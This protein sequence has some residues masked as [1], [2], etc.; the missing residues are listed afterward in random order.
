M[1]QHPPVPA[2]QNLHISFDEMDLQSVIA[3]F[4]GPGFSGKAPVVE[5]YEEVIA[6]YF[7]VTHALAACNGTV[8]IE[9]ALRGLGLG[10]G[11][12]IGLP[13][14]APIMSILP[15]LAVGAIPVFYDVEVDSFAPKL[16]DLR[17][18]ITTSGL[19]A[20][21][22]VPMWGYPWD[23]APLAQFCREMGLLLI[24]DCAHSFGTSMDGRKF[25]TFGDAST[26]STHERKLVSTGEGGFC[27]TPH[28]EVYARMRQWQHHGATRDAQGGE[29]LGHARGG[30][31]KLAPICAALGISQFAKLDAK[32][33]ARQE[34]VSNLRVLLSH[35]PVLTE[36]CRY[37]GAEVN[38]YA[39]VWWHHGVNTRALTK[40]LAD[41][42]V[43]SDTTRYNYK[44]LYREPAFRAFARPCPNAEHL[45][46]SILTLPCHEGLTHEDLDTIANIAA[47]VF[48]NVSSHEAA[49]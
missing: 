32:I 18:L 37:E 35:I 24:E 12:H 48:L 27:L 13:P 31:A 2:F 7:G 39:T 21:L 42:G 11:H 34:R 44:P 5:R 14:T 25:G 8:A 19:D 6:A 30:N 28:S 4:D 3:A 17:T 26:F 15:I 33:A 16:D 41:R 46:A 43:Q 38:G 10:P 40:Q 22:T 20:V 1:T 47:E 49:E 29:R 45:I 36:M 9:L 23:V